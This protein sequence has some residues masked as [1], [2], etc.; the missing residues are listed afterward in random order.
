[1]SLNL[2]KVGPITNT[3]I[4]SVIEECNKENTQEQIKYKVIDPLINHIAIKLQPYVI[5]VMCTFIILFILI[6]C[7]LIMIIK[8]NSSDIKYK[9]TI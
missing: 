2:E 7:I 1:M 9:V 3:V 4:N 6:T 8:S 5:A